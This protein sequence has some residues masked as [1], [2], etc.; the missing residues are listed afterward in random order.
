M[1]LSDDELPGFVGEQICVVVSFTYAMCRQALEPVP[2]TSFTTLTSF[3]T[4]VVARTAICTNAAKKQLVTILHDAGD[5]RVHATYRI[6][7][8]PT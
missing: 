1:V 2:T 6:D 8:F 7:F 4:S 3:T 5:S